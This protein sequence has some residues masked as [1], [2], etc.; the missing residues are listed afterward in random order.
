MHGASAHE[1]PDCAEQALELVWKPHKLDM[2]VHPPDED[3]L[4]PGCAEQV[5]ELELLLQG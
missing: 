4:Q 5:L 3:Q 2:P 1:Q